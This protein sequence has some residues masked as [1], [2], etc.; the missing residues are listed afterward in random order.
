MKKLILIAL[1]CS[2]L[3][4]SA[5]NYFGV[6]PIVNEPQ[7]YGATTGSIQLS[8]VGGTAPYQYA[9]SGGLPA[10]VVQNNVG[11]GTYMV[12]VT[13]ANNQTATYTVIVAQP[14]QIQSNPVVNAPQVHGTNTGSID[15]GI[16]GGTPNYT[17]QWSTGATTPTIS[18]L[19]GGIYYLTVTDE[20]G[21]A[22]DYSFTVSNAPIHHAPQI[23]G[24][25]TLSGDERSLNTSG[26][27]DP[28]DGTQATNA[29]QLGNRA[30]LNTADVQVYPNPATNVVTL[31]TG[32]VSNAL[33][34]LIDMN[35]QT[36]AQQKAVSNETN[37]NVS[38]LTKGNYIVEVKTE[39]GTVN[40]TITIVR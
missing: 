20:V 35:G 26:S 23:E 38:T 32:D 11:A 27:T 9:W 36:V 29:S 24:R 3:Y 2:A 12:T 10:T 31:K 15:P 21:C 33:I 16:S 7:C 40:K 19:Y 39:A 8:V 30:E 1:V 17:Y 22:S 28:K 13:D 6:K 14:F 25:A 4:S 5:S 18:N 34:S 37:V